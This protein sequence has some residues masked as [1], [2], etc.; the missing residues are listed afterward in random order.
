MSTI[1][2]AH[3]SHLI[4]HGA[5]HNIPDI[6]PTRLFPCLSDC[7]FVCTYHVCHIYYIICYTAVLIGF[8]GQFVSQATASGSFVLPRQPKMVGTNP[9]PDP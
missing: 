1:Y 6:V 9:N 8:G 7:L 3:M 4:W 2:Y 5:Y